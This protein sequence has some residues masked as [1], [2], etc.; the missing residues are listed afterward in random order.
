MRKLIIGIL[1]I[2]LTSGVV[3]AGGDQNQGTTGTGTITLG[4]GAQGSASQ[5]RTGR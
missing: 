2:V 5:P 3:F 1:F 4:D